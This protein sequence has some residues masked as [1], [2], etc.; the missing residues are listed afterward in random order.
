MPR[1]SLV[2]LTLNEVEGLRAVFDKIPRDSVDEILGIDGGSTDGTVEF[3][4]GRGVRVVRQQGK[5]R[6][7]AMILGGQLA[8]G[9]AAIFFSP[10]GNE[11]PRDIPKIVGRLN[12][13]YDLVIASRFMPG[14]QSDD[15]DDPLRIRRLGDNVFTVLVNRLWKGPKVTDSIN[16]YRGV[17]RSVM[18]RLNLDATYYEIEMQMTIRCKKLGYRIT[19]IPTIEFPRAEGT[20]TKSKTWKMGL[21]F[22]RAIIRELFMGRRF[23]D[24]GR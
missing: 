1:T 5:G 15:S 24:R 11:D 23:L 9:D 13:G 14:A 17:R 8:S 21:F 18:E 2:I 3:L 7:S 4:Q 19:E 16:G 20:K 22:A 12:E 6:G 10:D